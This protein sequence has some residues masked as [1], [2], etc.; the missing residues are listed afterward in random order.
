M[1][2]TR[3]VTLSTIA[4]ALNL[5][6]TTVSRALK[7][8][9][10]IPE[11]TRRLVKA[12]AKELGYAPDP[13][14]SSLIAYRSSQLRVSYKATLGWIT[15]HP[16]RDGWRE[17]EKIAYFRGVKMRAIELGYELEEFWLGAPGMTQARAIQILQARNIRGLFFVPEHGSHSQLL[18]DWSRFSSLTFGHTLARPI[19]HSVDTDHYRSFALLMKRLK[20][21]GYRRL[22]FAIWSIVQDTTDRN[23][24]A[25]FYAHQACAP[26]KQVPVF[27]DKPW[28]IE[29][30]RAWFEK[31]RPDVVI[32]H[33]ETLLGWIESWGL[34]VPE[35]VGFVLAARHGEAQPRCSGIDE[36]SAKVAEVAVNVLVDMINRGESGIPRIPISTLVEGTWFDGKTL[37]SEAPAALP[38]V[39]SFC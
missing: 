23:W 12:K 39:S 25:A 3:R 36:N 7:N 29:E 19:F 9:S 17:Y 31:Y 14:L 16:T 32:S 18:L 1:P 26:Q 38:E 20:Q 5:H 33:D 21:L 27:I 15:N 34:K 11:V 2:T 4:D 28:R 6:H 35:D 37:R 30:F 22:G 24:T 8:N 13:V 10:R